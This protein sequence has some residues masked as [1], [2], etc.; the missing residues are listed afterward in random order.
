MLLAGKG[1]CSWSPNH[2]YIRIMFLLMQ[3]VAFL[4]PASI[5]YSKP[6]G[7]SIPALSYGTQLCM[8]A[9][10]CC[11]KGYSYFH[12]YDEL[13]CP[14]ILMNVT[15]RMLSLRIRTPVCRMPA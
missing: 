12:F 14:K 6:L 1:M 3:A 10:L 5:H 11:L 8:E 4:E 9:P 15:V 13:V 7:F 2:S